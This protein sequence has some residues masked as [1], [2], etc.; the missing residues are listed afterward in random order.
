MMGDNRHNSEDS[1]YWGFV[2]QDHIVG[3]PVFIWM[4]M[5]PHGSGLGKV[6]WERLFTTVGGSG[7][8]YS[9]FKFFLIG[10][11]AYFGISFYMKKKKED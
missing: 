9:Y 3:K 4:S 10:L 7:Q 8:P 6:R 2:P 1:R 11:A 5:D